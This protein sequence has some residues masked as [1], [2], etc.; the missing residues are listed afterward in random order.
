MNQKQARKIQ[1]P[2]QAAA[3]EMLDEID[4][5]QSGALGLEELEQRLWRLLDAT[6]ERFPPTISSRVEDLVLQLQRLQRQNL[7]FH[8]GDS[9]ENRGTEEIFREVTSAL[10]RFV[11]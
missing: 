6:D 2:N 3:L 11:S 7:S 8:G 9:D 4:R 1:D 5:A 10:S